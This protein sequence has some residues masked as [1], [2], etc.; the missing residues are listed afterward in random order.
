MVL[1]DTG[2]RN[3]ASTLSTK[4]S[5][6]HA[7]QIYNIV[8]T[9][10]INTQTSVVSQRLPY[11]LYVHIVPY[12]SIT[13]LQNSSSNNNNNNNYSNNKTMNPIHTFRVHLA[14]VFVKE[15]TQ[16]VIC[17]F[18]YVWNGGKIYSQHKKHVKYSAK[19]LKQYVNIFD[20]YWLHWLMIMCTWWS[21]VRWKCFPTRITEGG[22][23]EWMWHLVVLYTIRTQNI[24]LKI[25]SR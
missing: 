16:Y 8:F 11:I 21:C 7:S 18:Y 17:Y 22:A 13:S 9:L 20:V 23:C 19:K 4:T 12:I 24:V 5:Y 10:Y 14:T 3:I 15:K 1:I 2:A 6:V 25:E